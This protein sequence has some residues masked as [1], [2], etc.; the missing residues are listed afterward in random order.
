MVFPA[1]M[2]DLHHSLQTRNNT[3]CGVRLQWVREEAVWYHSGFLQSEQMSVGLYSSL[4]S[5]THVTSF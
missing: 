3:L 2:G 1:P 5:C 4:P